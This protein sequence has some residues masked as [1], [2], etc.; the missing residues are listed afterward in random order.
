MSKQPEKFGNK[1]AAVIRG[2]WWN[3]EDQPFTRYSKNNS[4]NFHKKDWA[5]DLL[6]KILHGCWK[7]KIKEY[8]IYRI[9]N[10]IQEATPIY[11]NVF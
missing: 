10:G 9:E 8:A 7:G 6:N 5:L 4:E 2:R 11:K 1:A 3:P